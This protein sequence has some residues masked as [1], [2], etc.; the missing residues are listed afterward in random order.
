MSH[1]STRRGQV[2]PTVALVSLLAMCVAIGVYAGVLDDAL[3]V[4]GRRLAAP[5]LERVHDA[6]TSGG[7]V[8][9]RPATALDA[10]PSGYRLNLSIRAG[11]AHWTAGPPTTPTADSASRMVSVRLGPGRIRPGRLRVAVWR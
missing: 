4:A 1:S 10:A 2:E 5:T 9:G 6:L 8:V 11:G 7:V 3:P